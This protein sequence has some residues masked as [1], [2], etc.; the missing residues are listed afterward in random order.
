MSSP[1]GTTGEYTIKP[2]QDYIGGHIAI[3]M[4]TLIEAV[5]PIILYYAW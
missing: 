3:G 4:I 5:T 2:P 1:L